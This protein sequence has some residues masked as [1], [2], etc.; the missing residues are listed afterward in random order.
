MI[1][2]F[3]G[4]G[5]SQYAAQFLAE[6][7]NVELVSIGE[8]L[9]KKRVI[10]VPDDGE[11]VGF[12]YPV[13]NWGPPEAVLK[14]VDKLQLA[15]KNNYVFAIATCA[16]NV[17]DANEVLRDVMMANR[18]PL[19]AEFSLTMP[20]NHA[21]ASRVSPPS[22]AESILDSAEAELLHINEMISKR[23]SALESIKGSFPFIKT[24]IINPIMLKYF[25]ASR[26]FHTEKTCKGCG[27]CVKVCPMSNIRLES[28]RPVWGNH[29][30]NCLA[31]FHRCPNRAIECGTLTLNSGRYYNPRVGA[32]KKALKK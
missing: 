8:C 11:P 24:K 32:M 14:F 12:V 31:C 10:F 2:Y 4:T 30:E 29:C 27:T 7:Q 23:R 1:F 25:R 18:I 22:V 19:N 5:N 16:K 9:L 26:L 3:T 17:G 21:T 28:G 20:N 6:K 13:H 15:R